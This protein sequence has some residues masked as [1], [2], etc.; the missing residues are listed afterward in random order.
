[1][2]WRMEWE[3]ED[4]EM[5][6]TPQEVTHTIMLKATNEVWDFLDF[7]GEFS[8]GVQQPV[9][10][11]DSQLWV[12]EEAGGGSQE[13]ARKEPGCQGG[14]RREPKVAQHRWKK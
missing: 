6:L 13:A 1:M 2:E 14:A 4:Q 12:G 3:W 5:G 10:C 11:L 8:S 7:T 9:V